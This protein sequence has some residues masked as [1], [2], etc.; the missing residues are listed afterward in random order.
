MNKKIWI[1]VASVLVLLGAWA[2]QKSPK[3]E[4]AHEHISSAPAREKGYWT[5]PMH[6][7]IH[8]DKP[9]E[10]PI[11]HMK[12]VLVNPLPDAVEKTSETAERSSIQASP[13]QMELLGTQKIEVEKMT[14]TLK[15]PV[16]G[17]LIS[18][19][20]VAFHVYESDMRYIKP[21]LFFTGESTVVSV[22]EISGSIASVDSIVDPTSRTVRVV[23]NIK[24]SPGRLVSETT[25]SG[26]IEVNLPDRLGIPESSVLHTGTGDL[27]Y[28]VEN[29]TRL[30]PKKVKLGIKTESFY[31]VLGGLSAGDI[32][33]S[34]PNFLLDSE[35][36]IR[37][38]N[39]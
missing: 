4:D 7:Q 12:L 36:K 29:G 18:P 20:S 25:F 10:C 31:E 14:L 24:K 6:P 1:L 38:T 22:G 35:A 32:I 8:S 13:H 2:L 33:S 5:C 37:G 30:T 11:C 27:V 16:S 17:R 28:L 19:H 26:V 23:G 39:D 3:K 9:G 21:G 15:V 34:G